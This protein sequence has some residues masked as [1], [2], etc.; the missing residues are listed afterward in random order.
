ML[1]YRPSGIIVTSDDM[2]SLSTQRAL[3][4]QGET[5]QGQLS[6]NDTPYGSF[7][8][9]ARPLIRPGPEQ[10][11]RASNPTVHISAARSAAVLGPFSCD[12]AGPTIRRPVQSVSL[13]TISRTLSTQDIRDRS[14]S[15]VVGPRANPYWQPDDGCP[16]DP[17][18]P[19]SPSGSE[20]LQSSPLDE[21]VRQFTLMANTPSSTHST[22][23]LPNSSRTTR[24]PPL[25]GGTP[26]ANRGRTPPRCDVGPIVICTPREPSSRL[27]FHSASQGS[28]TTRH[29]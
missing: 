27:A 15:C 16:P 20:L 22:A 18:L 2:R 13:P 24:R 14:K 23:N 17:M 12:R 11:A 8:D 6:S 29:G 10:S 28:A 5:R 26:F 21:L 19:A 25:L 3:A 7:Q 9:K 1:R 4:R